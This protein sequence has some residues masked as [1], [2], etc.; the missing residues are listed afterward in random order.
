GIT[1][2]I[3]SSWTG[4]PLG[5]I[6]PL[7]EG[8]IKPTDF[9]PGDIFPPPVTAGDYS[10]SLSAFEGTDPNGSWSL[11]VADDSE[12]FGGI[13]SG[14]W[15]LTITTQPELLTTTTTL[16]DA[17]DNTLTWSSGGNAP[18]FAQAATVHDGIDAARSGSIT[19][20]QESWIETTV[21]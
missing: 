1:V 14:G 19:N 13:L 8:V 11:F 5:Q 15:D 21:T 17:T 9:E 16:A 20:N 3:D 12:P 4:Y 18:W 7:S 10:T 6:E 2:T